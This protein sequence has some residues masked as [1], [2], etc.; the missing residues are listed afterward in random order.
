MRSALATAALLTVAGWAGAAEACSC[1]R[2]A[3]AAMQMSRADLA[4]RGTVV[5]T[6]DTGLGDDA[7]TVFR[8]RETWRGQAR[9]RTIA[10]EHQTTSAICGVRFTPGAT[11]VVLATRAE[12]RW[13]TSL[14]AS[15][16]FDAAEYRRAARRR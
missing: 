7:R 12:G 10:V 9:S 2:E 4:F 8:V 16:Q 6:R 3:S 15:P 11:T 13:R 14:C 5:S 1:V